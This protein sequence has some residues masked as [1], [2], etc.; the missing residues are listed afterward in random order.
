MLL[1]DFLLSVSTADKIPVYSKEESLK[2]GIQNDE[3]IIFYIHHAVSIKHRLWTGYIKHGLD[4]K[5][6]IQNMFK[7][8]G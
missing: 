8:L 3:G 4:I 6:G 2:P 1:H 7:K 5:C